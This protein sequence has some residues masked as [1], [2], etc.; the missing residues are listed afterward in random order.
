M[1]R[2][3]LNPE[4]DPGAAVPRWSRRWRFLAVL[5]VAGIG[6]LLAAAILYFLFYR[7]S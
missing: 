6:W 4:F 2:S 5:V 7:H 1:R 3:L